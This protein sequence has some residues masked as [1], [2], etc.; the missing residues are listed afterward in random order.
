MVGDTSVWGFPNQLLFPAR[1]KINPQPDLRSNFCVS[2]GIFSV[3]V[4]DCNWC[5]WIF[6]PHL[7][8]LEGR[9]DRTDL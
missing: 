2:I 3:V 7:T 5:G 6:A 9:Q 1:E 8:Y 4:I